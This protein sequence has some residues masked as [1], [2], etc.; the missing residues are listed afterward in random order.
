MFCRHGPWILS[1]PEVGQER[2]KEGERSLTSAGI[3]RTEKIEREEDQ[4][5]SERKHRVMALDFQLRHSQMWWH[6]FKHAKSGQSQLSSLILLSDRAR[7]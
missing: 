1:F 4:Y 7:R 6:L 5:S 2:A 3:D